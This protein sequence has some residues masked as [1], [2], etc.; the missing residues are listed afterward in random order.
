MAKAEKYVYSFGPDGTDGDAS[1]RA[2]LG[3]KGA[4]LAEMTNIGL[5]V[6]AGF[7]IGTN[8]CTYFYAHDRTYP[9]ELHKP[10]DAGPGQDRKGDGRQVRL[11][12]PIRCWSPAAPV[13]ATRCP[14]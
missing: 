7:T 9:P 14:A 13:P 6:P 1:M 8:V 11:D 3:G 10:V 12:R 4:N 5:P 2:L